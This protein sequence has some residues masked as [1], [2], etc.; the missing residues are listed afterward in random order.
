MYGV[1]TEATDGRKAESETPTTSTTR[2][3][4]LIRMIVPSRQVSRFHKPDGRNAIASVSGRKCANS[5]QYSHC[6]SAVDLHS[7]VRCSVSTWSQQK[8]TAAR[9]GSLGGASVPLRALRG[10]GQVLDIQADNVPESSSR[11]LIFAGHYC[12]TQYL[13]RRLGNGS[14][15]D[16]SA[17]RH[18]ALSRRRAWG[19]WRGERAGRVRGR[20]CAA[21][22]TRVRACVLRTCAVDVCVCMYAGMGV[23]VWACVWAGA[24]APSRSAASPVRALKSNCSAASRARAGVGTQVI[25]NGARPSARCGERAWRRMAT[26]GTNGDEWQAACTRS[27]IS[28]HCAAR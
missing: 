6:G 8:A 10:P 15:W 28:L 24:P 23:W 12:C 4:C 3:E 17:R 16:G 14:A 13:D 18:R 5:W 7:G 11:T 22:G 20:A 26:N 2:R 25:G 1:H 21:P 9:N 27:H 19:A